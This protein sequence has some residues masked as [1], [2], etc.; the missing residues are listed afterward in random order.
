MEITLFESRIC[1]FIFRNIK[2]TFFLLCVFAWKKHKFFCEG[3]RIAK[4]QKKKIISM[5]F[6]YLQQT[7]KMVFPY[8]DR[9]WGRNVLAWRVHILGFEFQFDWI[10][11]ESFVLS[12]LMD[13]FGT[14]S[15]ANL[16][17]LMDE[18]WKTFDSSEIWSFSSC[19]RFDLS[20]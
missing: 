20:C 1:K 14:F 5:V 12:I 17:V 11:M 10:S 2:W 8:G 3:L 7:G 13:D 16:R 4:K 15:Y 18:L 9:C 6:H 19:F